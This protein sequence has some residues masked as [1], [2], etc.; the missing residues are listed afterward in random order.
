MGGNEEI[1]SMMENQESAVT[2]SRCADSTF[3]SRLRNHGFLL[4]VQQFSQFN[5]MIKCLAF[6]FKR[7]WFL[8]APALTVRIPHRVPE[9]AT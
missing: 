8:V 5:S 1:I 4:L 3:F 2:M 9:V 6:N 7:S